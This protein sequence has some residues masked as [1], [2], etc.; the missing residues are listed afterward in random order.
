[1]WH[2]W[3]RIG[4]CKSFWWESPKEKDHSED[5]SVDGKI[6]SEWILGK[7]AGVVSGVDSTGSG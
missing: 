2:A 5:R 4:K 3:E 7:L 1:M 6:G